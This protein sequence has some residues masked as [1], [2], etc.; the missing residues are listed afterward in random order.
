MLVTVSGITQTTDDQTWDRNWCWR[1][2]SVSV[3]K[4]FGEKFPPENLEVKG[5]GNVLV[6]AS[7]LYGLSTNDLKQQELDYYDHRYEI[8]ITARTVKPS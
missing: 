2:T 5:F 7:F 3:E 4:L 1:F 8:L 6:A